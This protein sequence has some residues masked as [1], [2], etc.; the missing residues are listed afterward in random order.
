MPVPRTQIVSP[1]DEECQPK[2][3]WVENCDNTALSFLP[4]G[5]LS[6]AEEEQA[7]IGAL[8]V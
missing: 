5:G 3:L 4:E 8:Q 7:D 6:F 2:H 1:K